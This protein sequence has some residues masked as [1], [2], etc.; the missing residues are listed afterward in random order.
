MTQTSSSKR[1]TC[2][3]CGYPGRQ[4]VCDLVPETHGSLTVWILQD[5]KEAKHAKNTARLFVL[6]YRQTKI[7]DMADEHQWHTFLQSVTPV[8]TILLYP[9]DNA[10]PLEL[11]SQQSR[12]TIENVVLL[13]GT[14]PKA[15][16][17]MLTFNELLTFPRVLF[18]SPPKSGYVIRKS[19]SD[20]ALSTFEAA[21]YALGILDREFDAPVMKAF[22]DTAVAR[23]WAQQPKAHKHIS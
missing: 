8:N 3:C 1:Q 19:P 2:R 18:S 14:W 15:K 17:M 16:K 12:S 4:C 6:G 23:Q 13:D 10:Q 5:K 9:D 11:V 22:F 20:T 21:S 7:I